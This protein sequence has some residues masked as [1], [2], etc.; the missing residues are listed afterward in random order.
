[1]KRFAQFV[2]GLT[3]MA[4]FGV[5]TARAQGTPASDLI[6]SAQGDIAATLGHKSSSSG[7]GELGLRV[8]EPWDLF[9]EIGRMRNVTSSAVESRA[10]IIGDAIGATSN[11]IQ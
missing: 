4:S 7:G 10:R 9:L 2:L 6:W 11:P 1:M 3:L 8:D 5:T